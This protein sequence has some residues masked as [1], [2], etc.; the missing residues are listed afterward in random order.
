MTGVCNTFTLLRKNVLSASATSSMSM[1]MWGPMSTTKT[2]RAC[3]DVALNHMGYTRFVVKRVL[4][5]YKI[6]D[7]IDRGKMCIVTPCLRHDVL[8]KCLFDASLHFA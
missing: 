4:L 2:V 3:K 7:I 8:M 1:C 5:V 6:P